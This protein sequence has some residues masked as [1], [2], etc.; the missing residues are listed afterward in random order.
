MRQEFVY[1][2][3]SL[4]F[5]GWGGGGCPLCKQT[6]LYIHVWKLWS[7]LYT[8]PW[9]DLSQWLIVIWR[10]PMSSENSYHFGISCIKLSTARCHKTD[11]THRGNRLV[12][13]QFLEVVKS[14]P[15]LRR[16]LRR[17]DFSHEAV[18]SGTRAP[19][20]QDK[21]SKGQGIRDRSPTGLIFLW[22]KMAPQWNPKMATIL[23]YHNND[24]SDCFKKK[25]CRDPWTSSEVVS[26]AVCQI[27]CPFMQWLYV[28]VC[29]TN[30][31]LLHS[32]SSADS[33]AGLILSDWGAG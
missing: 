3:T 33:V 25:E 2:F 7:A 26:L 30:L 31:P 28:Y 15:S 20:Q 21:R 9:G 22:F 16:R 4:T 8:L 13:Q 27:M 1:V 11:M 32:L 29:L 23:L 12:T 18:P 6:Q 10:R 19:G 17:H 14:K 24:K 5:R